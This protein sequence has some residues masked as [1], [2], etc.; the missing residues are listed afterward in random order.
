LLVKLSGVASTAAG[1]AVRLALRRAA[2]IS[3]VISSWP[4]PLT[5]ASDAGITTVEVPAATWVVRNPSR[6][7]RGGDGNNP[8]LYARTRSIPSS[9]WI[10][11]GGV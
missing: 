5:V 1:S 9:A 8:R 10:H 7:A 2:I 6:R 11:G 3:G 4:F